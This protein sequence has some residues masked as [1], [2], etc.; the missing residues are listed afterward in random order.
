MFCTLY[1]Q[2][3]YMQF[4]VCNLYFAAPGPA[5]T[6]VPEDRD[7]LPMDCNGFNPYHNPNDIKRFNIQRSDLLMDEVE[8]GSGNFGCVKKGVFK[9]ESWGAEHFKNR[10][11]AVRASTD[12]AACVLFGFRGQIDVAVK[13]LKNENEKLVKEEMMREAEIMHQLSNPFIVRMLGLCNAD[14]L[15]LVMEMASAGPL[16][17]FLSSNK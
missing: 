9:T 6:T 7:L 5:K 10:R 8:L 4:I 15:M 13:V 12:V 11:W 17:K 16:N 14:C 2:T 3:K 1:L